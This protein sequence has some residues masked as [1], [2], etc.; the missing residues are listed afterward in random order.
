VGNEEASGVAGEEEEN[1]V[2]PSVARNLGGSR[3]A[4]RQPVPQTRAT[5]IACSL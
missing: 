5:Q 2:I 3:G 1:V 4:M